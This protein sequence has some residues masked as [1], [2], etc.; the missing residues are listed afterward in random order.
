[1][2]NSFE[3][4]LFDI[5]KKAPSMA[6]EAAIPVIDFIRKFKNKPAIPKLEKLAKIDYPDLG[7]KVILVHGV[8][9]GEI[10][11]LENLLKRLKEEFSNYKLVITT[12]TVT[13]QELAHK[14]YDSFADFITYLP[15]D[16]K[17]CTDRFLDKIKPSVI[18]IAETELWPNLF[19]S[20]KERSIPLY[21]INGRI[22]DKSYPSYKKIKKFIELILDCT[23]GVF[24]QSELDKNRFIELGA[25]NAQVMKNL[26]FEIDKKPCDIDLKTK[27]YKTLIAAST[28]PGEE[29]IILDCFKTLKNKIKDLKLIIAPRH[30][31]RLDEVFA[32][33]KAFGFNYGLRTKGDNF[34]NFDII[35]LDTLG[36]LSKIYDIVDIAFIGGSF[37]KVFKEAGGHNP[38]EAVIYS[39]P[40]IS[41]PCIKNFRDIY[42]ILVHDGASFVVNNEKELQNAIY[43]LLSDDEFYNEISS[44]CT[45]CFDSQQGA[46]DFV[47]SKLKEILK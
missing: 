18:L 1:M 21:I 29:D 25:K 47:I 26:K 14:K 46:K 37:N 42:S 33:I 12:G 4:F 45:K 35:V 6:L 34:D 13:G 3:K 8:S 38:L 40:A 2:N 41:G 5:Y 36:E 17:E 31:T 32:S 15:L 30:L 39:K 28:H 23:A 22:S 9:V 20:A 24:C 11:S 7:D 27:N 44:N 10:Q 19:N 16:V 43:K